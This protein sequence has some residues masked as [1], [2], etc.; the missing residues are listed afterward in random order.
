MKRILVTGAKGFVGNHL[1]GVLADKG[2]AVRAAV[3]AAASTSNNNSRRVA[4][5]CEGAAEVVFVRDLADQDGWV[6]ALSDIDT[7]VHLAA[8]VHVMRE[9]CSDALDEFRRINRDA[10]ERLARQAAVA[11][12][13]RFVYLSTVKVNGEQ[14]FDKPFR[15][16]DPPH[17]EDAYS[18]SKWEAEQALKRV[19]EESGLEV[20][21]VRPPLVY[22]P[23][24]KGNFLTLLRLVRTGL[25]LPFAS[26]NNR[27]SFVSFDNIVDLI[28]TCV[29]HPGASGEVFLAADGEDLST[30]DLIRRI[31]RSMGK[32][33]P[34]FPFPPSLLRAASHLVRKRPVCDRLCGSLTV[35]AGKAKN[36]LGW[37]P[38]A[39][40]DDSIDQ[41]VR[42]FMALRSAKSGALARLGR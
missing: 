30:P 33:N 28:A 20:A 9:N 1:C 41:M 42:W 37:K 7:V 15:E 29:E 8:R 40:V 14:T 25:P 21:V 34:L 36:L 32:R 3:R 5:S 19:S 4:I 2:Y 12:V 11:G 17:P 18:I 27:R 22:G 24:V 16:T 39:S 35:D 31:A 10:T 23:G 13:R 26:I 38:V 6:T